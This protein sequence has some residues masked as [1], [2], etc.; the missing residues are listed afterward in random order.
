LAYFNAAA[1]AYP[2][3]FATLLSLANLAAL[4]AFYSFSLHLVFLANVFLHFGVVLPAHVAASVAS[5]AHFSFVFL[6]SS[7]SFSWVFAYLIKMSHSVLFP[8]KSHLLSIAYYSM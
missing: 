6:A 5:T 8:A 1:S 2:A 7:F 4:T 3:A